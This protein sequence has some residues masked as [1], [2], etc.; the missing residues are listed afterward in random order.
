[1]KFVRVKIKKPILLKNRLCFESYD[2][3]SS[4]L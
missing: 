3:S 1:V 2:K 4:P